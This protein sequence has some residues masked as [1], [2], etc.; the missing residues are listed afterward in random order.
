MTTLKSFIE[1]F[2]LL[3]DLDVALIDKLQDHEDR[4][5]ALEKSHEKNKQLTT[6][7]SQRIGE[8]TLLLGHHGLVSKK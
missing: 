1:R 5:S 7:N 3:C 4:L 2:K 8:I 6:G